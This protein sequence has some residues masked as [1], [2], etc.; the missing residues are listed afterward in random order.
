ML[1][2]YPIGLQGLPLT[3]KFG[4]NPPAGGFLEP[5]QVDLIGSMIEQEEMEFL[6]E[7]SDSD[8]DVRKIV[9]HITSLPD[10]SEED[11]R[12]QSEEFD[13]RFPHLKTDMDKTVTDTKKNDNH[14]FKI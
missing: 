5:H 10:L 9:E 6:K 4:L 12:R 14:L 3:E 7:L 11:W 2:K 13:K 1:L 8:P